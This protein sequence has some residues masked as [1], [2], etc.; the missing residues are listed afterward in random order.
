[1]TSEGVS[2]NQATAIAHS[3]PIARFSFRYARYQSAGWKQAA[4]LREAM[5]LVG[6]VPHYR[7]WKL[8][9]FIYEIQLVSK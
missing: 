8:F 7:I 5:S 6:V 3:S 1:M 9:L 2:T 4:P